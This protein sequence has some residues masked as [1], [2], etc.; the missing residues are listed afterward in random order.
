MTTKARVL[1]L[2]QLC[3]T[4]RGHPAGR[5]G[6]DDLSDTFAEMKLRAKDRQFNFPYLYDGETEAVSRAYGPVSTPHVF[7]FD[8]ERKLRYVGAID[9]SERIQHVTKNYLR[10][11]LDA[12]LAGKEPLVTQT[13]AVGCSIK[14]AGKEEQV[15]AYLD[16]LDEEPVS[17]TKALTKQY[18]KH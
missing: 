11:A 18:C 9:N 14:W 17:V 13:K 8:A 3:R 10:D 15:K 7:V 12:L 1:R 16:Q 6:I 4:T 2:L 5:I